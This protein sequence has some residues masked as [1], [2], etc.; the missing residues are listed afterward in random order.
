MSLFE[1]VGN[2]LSVAFQLTRLTRGAVLFLEGRGWSFLR[3][4][5][6]RLECLSCGGA[7]ARAAGLLGFGVGVPAQQ[8]QG[9]PELAYKLGFCPRGTISP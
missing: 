5:D 2:R 7:C 6:G 4:T 1:K 8:V 3:G 9:S